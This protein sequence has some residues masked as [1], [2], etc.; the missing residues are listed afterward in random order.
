[1]KNI[2]KTTKDKILNFFNE[3]NKATT[4][5]KLKKCTRDMYIK[6]PKKRLCLFISFG[7]WKA[8]SNGTYN[9]EIAV[10]KYGGKDVHGRI[11]EK[12]FDEGVEINIPC[13]RNNFEDTI[14]TA[15]N[16]IDSE[17]DKL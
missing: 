17:I 8:G 11:A 6:Q 1:M 12:A 2:T 9:I 14:L 15:L 16:M 3:I 10:A 13:N 7:S 5:T 4:Q